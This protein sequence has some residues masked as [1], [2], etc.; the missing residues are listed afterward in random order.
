MVNNYNETAYFN[1]ERYE[2]LTAWFS[3]IGAFRIET[4]TELTSDQKAQHMIQLQLIKDNLLNRLINSKYQ[5]L[6][7]FTNIS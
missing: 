6:N 7:L 3:L 4:D 2:L 1:Q 5:V